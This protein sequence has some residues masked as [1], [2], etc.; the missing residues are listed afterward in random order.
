MTLSKV[1]GMGEASVFKGDP[2]IKVSSIDEWYQGVLTQRAPAV[3]RPHLYGADAGLCARRNV[4]LSRNS[5]VAGY[6]PATAQ[7]YMAMGV[8]LEDMLA[9]GLHSKGRL[10]IQSLVLPL[11]PQFKISGKI[12]LVI[13]DNQ[14]ELALVEVKTCGKLP[15]EPKPTHLAQIQTYAAVSGITRAWLTYISRDVR[16]D[17]GEQL[18]IRSFFVD[19]SR[20]ALHGRLTTAA[21]SHLCSEAA[22]LPPVPAHFRKHQECH[23]CEFRDLFCYRLRPGLGGDEPTTPMVETTP[24]QLI[25][26]TAKAEDIA[27][28]IV[29]T[30]A[31]RRKAVLEKL[32]SGSLSDENRVKLWKLMEE[33]E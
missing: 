19:C 22:L 8:G 33:F 13:F 18:A 31:P 28:A 4:L 7:A 12:D 9:A 26:L 30:S 14:D 25:Q 21:L 11:F 1:E 29:Q 5:W 27:Q 15:L 20:E 32:L 10:L 2:R 24:A 6:K 17:F 23:Y 3:Q 16:V